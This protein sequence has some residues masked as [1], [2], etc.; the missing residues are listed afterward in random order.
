[1]RLDGPEDPDESW[2]ITSY[3]VNMQE[4]TGNPA[5]KDRSNSV[6]LA[7]GCQQSGVGAEPSQSGSD[8]VALA[9][10]PTIG[11]RQHQLPYMEYVGLPGRF[12]HRGGR[13]ID[14]GHGEQCCGDQSTGAR[15]TWLPISAWTSVFCATTT[16]RS[17]R[18][19]SSLNGHRA[20]TFPTLTRSVWCIS[21]TP[22]RSSRSSNTSKSPAFCVPSPQTP[23][24]KPISRE[25][26]AFPKAR[27]QACRCF[28]GTS[29]PAP[30][31]SSSS[32][33]GTGY[34]RS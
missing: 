12:G 21:R 7:V 15:L 31:A 11:T 24:I 22:T 6:G 10:A 8:P 14:G 34:R 30:W 26:R 4:S 3:L 9:P 23:T 29:P 17:V 18:Q 20:R 1:M 16:T 33:T 25:L 27:S 32:V 28:P 5:Y 19:C 13:R 2:L